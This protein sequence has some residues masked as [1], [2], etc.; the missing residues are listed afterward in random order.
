[1]TS[2]TV[3]AQPTEAEA[4]GST[5]IGALPSGGVGLGA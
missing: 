1:M 5:L 4:R 3:F 2:Y